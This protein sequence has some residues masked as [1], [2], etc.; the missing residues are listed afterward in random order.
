M[1]LKPVRFGYLEKSRQFQTNP[2]GVEASRGL[3]HLHVLV[4]FQTNP[5]GVEAKKRPC[6]RWFRGG[7]RRT[8]VGLKR[9][10]VRL[11]VVHAVRFR[12]TLVG[13]KPQKRNRTRRG[14]GE[15]QTNPCGVEAVFPKGV[16][17][18]VYEFQT[19]PCG[20]EARRR[21]Y[22]G[23]RV[24]ARFRRTLV[25]LKRERRRRR[26]AGRWSFRRTLVGLKRT[27]F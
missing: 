2:C 13:L 1:G 21:A 24:P 23:G 26:R 14:T 12:R 16:F 9:P 6:R 20:V 4:L 18:A 10:P 27:G 8:L 7:F 5:C 17:E 22:G 3:P 15:F 25:G 11:G 19:N